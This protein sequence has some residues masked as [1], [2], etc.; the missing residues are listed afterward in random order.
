MGT[1]SQKP[2]IP[3]QFMLH[4]AYPNPFNPSTNIRFDIM[5]EVK[6]KL[7]VYDL[8]GRLVTTLNNKNLEPGYYEINWDARTVASGPY[9]VRLSAG[10]FLNTQKIT[11]IK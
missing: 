9:F 5:E 7:E 10:S 3:E 2:V 6:V 1:M 8:R 4:H 11:L